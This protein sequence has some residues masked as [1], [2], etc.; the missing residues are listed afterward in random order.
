[1]TCVSVKTALMS[2]LSMSWRNRWVSSSLVSSLKLR[3]AKIIEIACVSLNARDAFKMDRFCPL[4]MQ[5]PSGLHWYSLLAS[6]RLQAFTF[7]PIVTFPR[8]APFTPSLYNAMND[9]IIAA[10]TYGRLPSKA[11][12][13]PSEG[14]IYF[15]S[16]VPCVKKLQGAL[17]TRES[18]RAVHAM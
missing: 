13:L 4:H 6:K 7:M 15:Q 14:S 12:K 11:R 16:D 1:M 10:L 8:S 3:R 17:T 5:G 2:I 18:R 9:L